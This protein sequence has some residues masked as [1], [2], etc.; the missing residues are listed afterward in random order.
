MQDAGSGNDGV[1][2]GRLRLARFGIG[3]GHDPKNN[4]AITR[5][6]VHAV[7]TAESIKGN[8]KIIG[9]KR[10]ID[11][12]ARAVNPHSIKD[13]IGFERHLRWLHVHGIA[14]NLSTGIEAGNL[15]R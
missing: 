4:R 15:S 9:H 8:G 13:T 2:A 10:Y 11:H 14:S 5:A 1:L 12:F 7:G 6:R 3:G